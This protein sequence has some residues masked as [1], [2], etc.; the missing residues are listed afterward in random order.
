MIISKRKSKIIGNTS[1]H[2]FMIILS[3]IMI[4]PFIWAVMSSFKPVEQL[5]SGNPLNIIPTEFTLENYKRLM[6]VLPFDK[7]LFNSIFLSITIPIAMIIV[8]SLAA[9]AVTRIEFKG[10]NILFFAFIA[11]MMIPSHVTLIPNYKIIVD[12]NLYNSF[13]AIFLSSMFTASNAF[14]IFFFRQYFLS[15]PKDLENAAIV[16][17]CSKIG[18]FFKIV[19]PNAKPAIAT[20]AILS[21][22]NVWNS[23]LWPMLVINDYDKLPLTVGLNYLKGSEPNW[24]VLLAGAT[25]SIIPI[26]IIF[27][28]FQ[29]YFM[30]STMNSGFGGK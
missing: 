4:Y 18:I 2:I 15:I 3:L 29:K 23:F 26:V 1:Y 7:M 20:T 17:G 12:M 16:D 14:N 10:R 28:V 6:E 8:A 22:R 19:L 9:Y 30:A 13:T 5:Y 21:F 24:A 27:L 11:T 25:L